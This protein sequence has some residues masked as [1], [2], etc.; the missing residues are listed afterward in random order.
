[1]FKIKIE[2]NIYYTIYLEMHQ[3]RIKV[4]EVKRAA[5]PD[6]L[7]TNGDPLRTSSYMFIKNKMLI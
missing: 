5:P 2:G 7:V 6:F 4:T 1:M 3:I